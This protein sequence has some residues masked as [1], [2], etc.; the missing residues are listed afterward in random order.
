[1]D[2]ERRLFFFNLVSLVEKARS[3]QPSSRHPQ[4][5]TFPWQRG[6]SS[7]LSP[8]FSCSWGLTEMMMTMI[9]AW[10]GGTLLIR[11]ALSISAPWGLSEPSPWRLWGY[12]VS[13]A[14][15]S[16]N[17]HLQWLRLDTGVGSS[18]RHALTRGGSTLRW[19]SHAVKVLHQ[20]FL[21]DQRT[22]AHTTH[23]GLWASGQIA[24]LL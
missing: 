12:T 19:V 9:P 23:G 5:P 17:S 4:R 11:A 6:V 15:L 13:Q 24:L 16:Q 18:F 10:T 21:A 14:S 7:C 2:T 1:M 3:N 8:I 20:V 22:D